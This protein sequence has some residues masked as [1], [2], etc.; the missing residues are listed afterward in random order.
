ME[1]SFRSQLFGAPQQPSISGNSRSFLAISMI[2]QSS[3]PERAATKAALDSRTILL[4]LYARW[5]D[6]GRFFKAKF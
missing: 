3:E 1:V 2:E 6:I 4:W 5:S